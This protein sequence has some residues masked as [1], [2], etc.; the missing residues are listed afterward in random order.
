[1][2]PRCSYFFRRSRTYSSLVL[3]IGKPYND[4]MDPIDFGFQGDGGV[5][6][7]GFS[8]AGKPT[9]LESGNLGW[10]A[11]STHIEWRSSWRLKLHCPIVVP[12]SNYGFPRP[13]DGTR[14]YV[15]EPSYCGSLSIKERRLTF[16]L[17]VP[18]CL[19]PPRKSFNWGQP[20]LLDDQMFHCALRL[21]LRNPKDGTYLRR[22]RAT[23]LRRGGIE[24]MCTGLN[25]DTMLAR[26]ADSVTGRGRQERIHAFLEERREEY[27][28]GNPRTRQTASGRA[29]TEQNINGS[30]Y[31]RLRSEAEQFVDSHPSLDQETV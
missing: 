18:D 25:G 4:K 20:I 3:S 30:I 23:P 17:R 5:L 22:M 11:V 10:L 28:L 1:M 12:K 19:D 29:V 26:V 31:L 21:E 14:E 2:R 9:L 24:V 27:L 8:C 7:A 6:V 15:F 16:T 13:R